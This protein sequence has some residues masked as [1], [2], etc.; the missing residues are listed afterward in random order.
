MVRQF[1]MAGMLVAGISLLAYGDDKH[2]PLPTA[3]SNAGF[4]KM[5]TLVGT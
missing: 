1:L 4:E 3:A 5:K 2:Q